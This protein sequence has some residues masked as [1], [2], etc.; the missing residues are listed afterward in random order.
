LVDSVHWKWEV[1]KGA[2]SATGASSQ[3]G[4]P[5]GSPHLF[6]AFFS[7]LSKSGLKDIAAHPKSQRSQRPETPGV[8]NVKLASS[9]EK[10]TTKPNTGAVP[11]LI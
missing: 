1:R 10:L 2:S 8:R 6:D 7:T 11:S 5:A 3:V 9:M 4:T